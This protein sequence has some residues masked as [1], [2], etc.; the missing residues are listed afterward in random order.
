MIS[1]GAVAVAASVL[2]FVLLSFPS[3]K[4]DLGLQGREVIAWKENKSKM[5]YL[6]IRNWFGSILG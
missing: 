3:L 6:D 2:L 1:A 5:N 4:L